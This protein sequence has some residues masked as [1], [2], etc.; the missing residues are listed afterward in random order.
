[1]RIRDEHKEA[2]V[3][4]KAIEMIVTEGF[5]GMSMQKLQKY[6]LQ[7]FISILRIGKIC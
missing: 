7:R 6:L 1:L 2:F 5:D 4:E 3:R